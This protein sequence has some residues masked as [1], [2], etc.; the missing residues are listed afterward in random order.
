MSN[1]IV[2]LLHSQ[3]ADPN[4]LFY[5]NARSEG[6][7]QNLAQRLLPFVTSRR[8]ALAKLIADSDSGAVQASEKT[9]TFWEVKRVA[10]EKFLQVYETAQK[11]EGD[12]SDDARQSRVEYLK[13]AQAAWSALKDVLTTLN[14]EVIGPYVLG[15]SSS[16]RIKGTFAQIRIRVW[17]CR[18]PVVHCRPAP[19]GLACPHSITQWGI[20]I[21]GWKHGA[22]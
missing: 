3:A 8:D 18:R 9:K 12:L 6:E 15:G 4:A 22:C 17:L 14:Q 11:R 16:W 19:R 10:A 20:G 1:Q 13:S 5:L 21:R 7:L 2:E